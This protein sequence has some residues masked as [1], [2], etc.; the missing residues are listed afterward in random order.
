MKQ[1]PGA[2]PIRAA[3]RAALIG[4][5]LSASGCASAPGAPGSGAHPSTIRTDPAGAAV[6]VDGGFVGTTPASFMLPA[7]DRVD[8]RLELP[9]YM[10]HDDVLLRA[11]GT[12]ADAPA[13]VG[14]DE[15]YHFPLV[16]K[17]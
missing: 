15:V 14:W 6:F 11:P 16:R 4:V 13:G 8:L 17:G 10:S 5:I 1:L 2:G 9:G 12:P 7:K 3:I